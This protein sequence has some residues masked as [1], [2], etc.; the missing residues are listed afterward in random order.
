MRS[1]NLRALFFIHLLTMAM[2]VVGPE[3]KGGDQLCAEALIGL[4]MRTICSRLK[5]VVIGEGV[6]P[7]TAVLAEATDS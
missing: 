6:P 3:T 1:T 5:I 4:T 7:L 2:P